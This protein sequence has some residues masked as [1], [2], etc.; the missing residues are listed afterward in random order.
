MSIANTVS[1]NTLKKSLDSPQRDLEHIQ[2]QQS[3]LEDM[4]T[5]LEDTVLLVNLHS[6]LINY[7]RTGLGIAVIDFL[8]VRIA[9]IMGAAVPLFVDVENMQV[10]FIVSLP[11]I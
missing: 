7:H 3:A 9:Y 11:F 5:T 6:R 1:Y 8:Q 10:A 2:Q 4:R